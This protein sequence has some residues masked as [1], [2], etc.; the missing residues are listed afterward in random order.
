MMIPL[1][2]TLTPIQRVVNFILEEIEA[3]LSDTSYMSGIDELPNVNPRGIL[4]L[5]ANPKSVEPIIT[6]SQPYANYNSEDLSPHLRIC[7]FWRVTQ[8]YQSS[9]AKDLDVWKKAALIK[10]AVPT[11]SHRME[12][13]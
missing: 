3:E 8:L 2:P 10:L 6:T 9:L 5:E 7:Y 13:L 12:T 4:L 1:S 11:S